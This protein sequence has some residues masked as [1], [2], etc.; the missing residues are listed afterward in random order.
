METENTTTETNNK[1]YKGQCK[2]FNDRCGYGFI[3]YSTTDNLNNP[4]K[5]IFVHFTNI[6]SKEE[7]SYKALQS[8]EYVQFNI[9]SCD[10]KDNS[11]SNATR[12]QAVNI[13]GIDG[14]KL[15]NEYRN[16]ISSMNDTRKREDD[17]DGNR[18]FTRPNHVGGKGRGRNGFMS[19]GNGR[20]GN[21]NFRGTPPSSLKPH[22]EWT[23][24]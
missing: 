17:D 23:P 12:E 13:T 10:N 8:G 15:L 5:D 22:E 9:T 19:R 20:Q 6:S 24:K 11:D 16:H 14:G 1:I 2:W 21:R 7:Q 4:N 18:V 3:S